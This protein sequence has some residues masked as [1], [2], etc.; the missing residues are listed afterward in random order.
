MK[1]KKFKPLEKICALVALAGFLACPIGIY[2][3][4]N[5]LYYGGLLHRN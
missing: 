1:Y 3:K 4:S 5:A 2:K